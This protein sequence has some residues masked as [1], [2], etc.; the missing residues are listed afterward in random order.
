[1]GAAYFEDHGAE[2]YDG[3]CIVIAPGARL[4]ARRAGRCWLRSADP[5]DKPRIL[6]NS[7]V[8]ARGR[9]VA[10]RG[11]ASSRARSP[12]RRRWREIVVQ[13]AQARAPTCDD[14]DELE[15]D[16]RR[17]LMLIYHPVGT[18]RMGDATSDAVVDPQLRVHGLEGLRVVD[19]SV[20]P[21]IPGGNTNAPTIMIAEQGRRPDPGPRARAGRA[22]RPRRARPPA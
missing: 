21:M 2:E 6:T 14:R 5:A 9:R 17:R 22:R 20:M 19:A 11:H 4:A 15:A 16:L 7:L 8:R 12:R 10:G 18:C 13:R 1:M 3:H